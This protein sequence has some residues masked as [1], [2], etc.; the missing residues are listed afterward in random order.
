MSRKSMCCCWIFCCRFASSHSNPI[1]YCMHRL[2]A[3]LSVFTNCHVHN[4]M[5]A[6]AQYKTSLRPTMENK[7]PY[8]ARIA[9]TPSNLVVVHWTSDGESTAPLDFLL[10]H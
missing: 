4:R 9:H 8:N 6:I 1:V 2:S 10:R 3:Q 5:G 7:L